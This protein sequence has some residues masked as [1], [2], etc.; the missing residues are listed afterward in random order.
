[1]LS[2]CSVQKL[3]RP[4]LS[5]QSV[6]MRSDNLSD[7]FLRVTPLVKQFEQKAHSQDA[8]LPTETLNESK[9]ETSP[10]EMEGFMIVKTIL[11]QKIPSKRVA[12][13]DAQSYFAIMLDDNNRKTI[14]RLYLNGNKKFFAY[15]DD[16]KKEIKAEISSLDDIFN[17][18]ETLHKIV[19]SYDGADKKGAS[20]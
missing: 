11:R 10:E 9:V 2:F 14:F 1:M 13:R 5:N 18:A 20:S 19:A 15:F 17:F 8:M 12:F 4:W 6:C 16:Q 7:S 3:H